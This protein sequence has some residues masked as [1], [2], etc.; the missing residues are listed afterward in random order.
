MTLFYLQLIVWVPQTSNAVVV[1]P[2]TPS[3]VPVRHRGRLLKPEEKYIN[4]RVIFEIQPK[5]YEHVPV[6]PKYGDLSSVMLNEDSRNILPVRAK[7]WH[8]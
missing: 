4:P 5:T 6:A 7:R 8:K 2:N 3:D 1:K